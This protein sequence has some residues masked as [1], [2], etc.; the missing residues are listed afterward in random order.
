M[1]VAALREPIT[2]YR[3]QRVSDGRGGLQETETLLDTLR[4]RVSGLS[5][6][7]VP[8]AIAERLSEQPAYELVVD[9]PGATTPV[10][11]EDVLVHASGQYRVLL[12]WAQGR[13]TY[14]LAA[15]R[16]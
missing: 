10:A 14:I 5:Q 16:G 4:G 15:R 8:T 12:A 9:T 7:A 6:R 1:A 3:V 2:R 11:A 13:V